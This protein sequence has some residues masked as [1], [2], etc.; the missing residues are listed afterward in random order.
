MTSGEEVVFS[1]RQHPVVLFKP[2]VAWLATMAVVTVGGVVLLARTDSVMAER[3]LGAVV[4][5]STGYAVART[6]QWW[7]TRYVITEERVMLI[8]GV[9][10]VRVSS[11]PLS[12]VNDTSF[13]RSL[14]G[15]LFGFGDLS[16]ES[17]GERA[18]LSSLRFLPKPR[19]VYRLV[20]SLLAERDRSDTPAPVPQHWPGVRATGKDDTGPLPR[21]G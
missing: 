3:A 16:L 13:S 6:L 19:E 9:I 8:S 14:W 11:I 21:F 12:K 15:R 7:A 20:A 2:L 18:G 4:L 1:S 10:S 17:A 5:L